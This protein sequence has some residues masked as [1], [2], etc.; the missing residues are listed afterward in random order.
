MLDFWQRHIL[1]RA[2]YRL[3]KSTP[4]CNVIRIMETHARYLVT[5]NKQKLSHL[6]QD[7]M[8]M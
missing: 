6:L 8:V 5:Q 4:G 7:I 3:N 2:I 1:F